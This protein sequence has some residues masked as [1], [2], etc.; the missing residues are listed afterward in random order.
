MTDPF[1][2]TVPLQVMLDEA[3]REV[4]MRQRVYWGL[5]RNRKLTQE[6]ADKQMRA[7]QGICDLIEHVMRGQGEFPAPEPRDRQ[8][9]LL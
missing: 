4:R 1:R 3:R 8:R 7:M 2:H 9:P 6:Q 5:V